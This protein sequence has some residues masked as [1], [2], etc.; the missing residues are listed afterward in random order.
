MKRALLI[1][2]LL[3]AACKTNT[4]PPPPSQAQVVFQKLVDA[5]CIADSDSGASDVALE[6]AS[7]AAPAWFTC[8]WNGGSV[9]S[10]NA[11]CSSSSTK[12]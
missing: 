7:D 3:G 9:A 11:P 10:C 5:G 8:V 2:L 1:T 12:K 6:E 4:P